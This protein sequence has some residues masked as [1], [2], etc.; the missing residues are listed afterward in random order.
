MI[1]LQNI[2]YAH[3]QYGKFKYI[4]NFYIFSLYISVFK[5]LVALGS[6]LYIQE[7]SLRLIQII[8]CS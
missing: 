5:R 2:T 6:F 3:V 4:G 7:Q 1:K 8:Q